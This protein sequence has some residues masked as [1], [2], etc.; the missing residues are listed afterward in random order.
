PG[1]SEVSHSVQSATGAERQVRGSGTGDP[2][3]PALGTP[4]YSHQH[5]FGRVFHYR[6]EYDRSLQQCRRALEL[7]PNDV[8]LHVVQGL[9]YEQ[10]GAYGEAIHELENARELSG[11]NPLILGPLGSCYA[12]SG[13][14]ELAMELIDELD[15]A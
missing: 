4:L 12:G 5:L 2:H 14:K 6:R 3:R 15:Q 8:E 11:N 1:P 7:D 9:N 13:K 10:K